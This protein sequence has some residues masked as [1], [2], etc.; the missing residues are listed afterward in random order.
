M[1]LLLLSFLHLPFPTIL[2]LPLPHV[3]SHR[4]RK[5]TLSLG[6]PEPLPFQRFQFLRGGT[7]D[8]V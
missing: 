8:H 6:L 2:L 4:I 5:Q 7:E 3:L 1:N